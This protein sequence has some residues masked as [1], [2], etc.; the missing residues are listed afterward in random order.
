MRQPDLQRQT[1]PSEPAPYLAVNNLSVQFPTEDGHSA[2][3]FLVR[4]PLTATNVRISS[5]FGWRVHPILGYRRLH[6][7]VDYAATVMLL[8]VRLQR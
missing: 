2:K 6:P 3:K 5:Q 8:G 4:K 1:E 7:G